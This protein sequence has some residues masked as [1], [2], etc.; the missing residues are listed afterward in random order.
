[1]KLNG[2]PISGPSPWMEMNCSLT[3]SNVLRAADRDVTVGAGTMDDSGV[4]ICYRVGHTRLREALEAQLATVA[5]A[6]G[7]FIPLIA[8]PRQRE[9]DA[10][11]KAA[12]HDAALGQRDERRVD[13]QMPAILRARLGRQVR[14]LHESVEKLLPA[15]GI[16]AIVEHIYADKDIIRSHDFCVGGGEAEEDEVAAWDVGDRDVMAH[17]GERAI[18]GHVDVI[19]QRA[20]AES[21]QIDG[22][23]AMI[24]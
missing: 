10:K 23:D 2:R 8:T 5:R 17:L 9:G 14:R 21:T 18:M 6:A 16:A 22:D 13:L 24:F 4:G 19:R 20:A 3:R 15:I 12:L 11:L 1:M 7:Q